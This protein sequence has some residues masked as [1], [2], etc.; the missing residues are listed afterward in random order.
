MEHESLALLSPIPEERLLGWLAEFY[1]KPV[2]IKE[3][4]LLRHRDL[5]RVE[6]LH[7]ADALP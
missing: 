5:S 4:E 3:R 2:R 6:R 7:I 1:G